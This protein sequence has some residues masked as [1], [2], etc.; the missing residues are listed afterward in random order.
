MTTPLLAATL[1]RADHVRSFHVRAARPAGW[2]AAQF[3][4]QRVVQQ[5]RCTD[6]HQVELTLFSFAREIAELRELGWRDVEAAESE[7]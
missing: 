6:W 7:T 4:D 3:E 2:E 5:R 1:V